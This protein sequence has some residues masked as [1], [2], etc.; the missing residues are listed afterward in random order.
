MLQ[1]FSLIT[2]SSQQPSSQNPGHKTRGIVRGTDIRTWN[3][4]G[5]VGANLSRSTPESPEC[6]VLE[7]LVS[8]WIGAPL[9]FA[10]YG[11]LP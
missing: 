11:V 2:M 8:P 4:C 7:N 1:N 3:T 5:G 9:D 10:P 6:A